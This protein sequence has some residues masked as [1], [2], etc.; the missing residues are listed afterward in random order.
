[1]RDG[2]IV[3]LNGPAVLTGPRGACPSRWTWKTP[4][5]ALIRGQTVNGL[6]RRRLLRVA[7]DTPAALTVPG[8]K[9]AE[10]LAAEAAN[11][12]QRRAS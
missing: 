1:M 3:L 7:K 5:G 4:C 9:L 6:V 12:H 8:R 10:Q 11:I 2:L